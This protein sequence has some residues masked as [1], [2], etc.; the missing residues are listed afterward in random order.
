VLTDE[1]LDALLGAVFESVTVDEGTMMGIK[2]QYRRY[3]PLSK[4][5]KNNV[6]DRELMVLNKVIV[7]KYV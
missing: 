7:E 1:E 4:M 5:E 6:D 2:E 3:S